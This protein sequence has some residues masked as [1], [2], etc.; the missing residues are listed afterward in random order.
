A[1]R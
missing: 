1:S